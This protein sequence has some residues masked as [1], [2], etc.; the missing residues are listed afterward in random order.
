MNSF[1]PFNPNSVV[2]PNLFAGRAEDVIN[3]SK[4][5]SQLKHSMPASF[6]IYGERGIGKTA[7]AKSIKNIAVAHDDILYSL[8]LL[9]NYYSVEEGQDFSSVLQASINGLTDQMDQNL[10]AEIGSKLGAIF[11]NGKFTI[12]AF[13]ASVG[14]TS[15]Q[16]DA[17]RDITIKDQT[18]SILRNLIDALSRNE[19]KQ[20][21]LIVIDET[22]NLGNLEAAASII[23][24]I[25]TTLDV[26]GKGR[27]SFLL[28]G[29]GED[30]VQFFSRDASARRTF[31]LY[32]LDVMPDA[33]AQEILRKGFAETGIT[34]DEDALRANTQLAGGYP[35]S[36]Q[37][38]GHN[39][40]EVDTDGVIAADDWALA[41]TRTAHVLTTKEFAKMY[42]FEK[43]LTEK[44]K[45]LQA[46][47]F[48]ETDKIT[49]KDLAG[50]VT[51]ANLSKAV[52]ALKS[53]GAI[54]EN[55][56]RELTLHNQLFRTAI[57][58]N[59]Y[60]RRNTPENLIS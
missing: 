20:G 28:I 5:L 52:T 43:P 22:H 53:I 16:S 39:L 29:Y 25:V 32:K 42:A 48:H 58:F 15:G 41:T 54:K 56:N 49:R 30:I 26:D 6:Y 50:A 21:V 34:W 10:V 60:V 37:I 35:H 8:D 57:R 27:I 12:G 23:R 59:S 40:I 45:V 31:D 51:I 11:K 47:A 33:D 19:D 36:I 24:N 44:D 4:K 55:E 18:V 38:L 17:Q 7:L 46:M 2:V 1:N 13:G 3:I 14:F 9:T